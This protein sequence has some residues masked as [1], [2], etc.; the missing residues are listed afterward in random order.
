MA[1]AKSEEARLALEEANAA[2]REH[3]ASRREEIRFMLERINAQNEAKLRAHAEGHAATGEPS[4]D[5]HLPPLKTPSRSV[6]SQGA[7]H[8]SLGTTHDG[9]S[10]LDDSRLAA[11]PPS[12]R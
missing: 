7:E 5:V 2:R 9:P 12:A 4:G 6:P 1:S 10:A 8:V 3:G 11:P